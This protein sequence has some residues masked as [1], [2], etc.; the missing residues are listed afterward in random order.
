MSLFTSDIYYLLILSFF[1]VY[2]QINSF[3]CIFDK[4]KE[5]KTLKIPNLYMNSSGVQYKNG[6]VFL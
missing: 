4:Q 1:I 6:S 3:I 5:K 2:Y